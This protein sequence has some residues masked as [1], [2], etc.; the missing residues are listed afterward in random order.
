MTPPEA[1]HPTPA[2]YICAH[3]CV[4]RLGDTSQSLENFRAA[5][6]N[7]NTDKNTLVS[8][9]GHLAARAR[10]PLQRRESGD[11]QVREMLAASQ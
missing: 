8:C 5:A 3:L 9:R 7:K 1:I 10:V 4:E 2:G 11:R 6:V